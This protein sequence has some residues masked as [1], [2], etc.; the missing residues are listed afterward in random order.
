M[1]PWA[2]P[3]HQPTPHPAVSDALRRELVLVERMPLVVE[4]GIERAKIGW[5]RGQ[6]IRLQKT[7][8]VLAQA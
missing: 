2:V 6:D 5:G 3:R 8:M 4:D 7:R 1:C